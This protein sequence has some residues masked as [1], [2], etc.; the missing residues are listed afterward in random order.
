[1]AGWSIPIDKL[2]EKM[3]LEIAEVA[4]KATKD[5]FTS[6]NYKSPVDTGRFRGNWNVSYAAPDLT[7]TDNTDTSRAEREIAKVDTLPVGGII[8]LCNSL[9]YARTLEY[10]LYPNPPKSPT[11]KTQGGYSRQAPQGM[12][13]ITALEFNDYVQKALRS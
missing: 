2:A 7:V 4:R 12:V 5:V 13:R 3:E 10:G 8:Y 6:V 11:G 9:P 1:M